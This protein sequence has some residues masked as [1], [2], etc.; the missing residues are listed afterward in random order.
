MTNPQNPYRSVI[1]NASA[2]SGKT[3]QL[4]HRFLCLVACGASPDTILTITF[5]NKAAKEMRQR[6]L[7]LASA[8]MHDEAKAAQFDAQVTAFHEAALRENEEQWGKASEDEADPQPFRRPRSAKATAREVLAWS[9]R[10]RVITIDAVF[11]N[12]QSRFAYEAGRSEA[13]SRPALGRLAVA[14]EWQSREL[15]E[16][17][18][19]LA[20]QRY[21]EDQH[22]AA[23][24]AAGALS[25]GLSPKE[26]RSRIELLKPIETFLWL[27]H[28]ASGAAFGQLP[29]ERYADAAAC[30]DYGAWFRQHQDEVAV[31]FTAIGGKKVNDRLAAIAQGDISQLQSP[32]TRLLKGDGLIS[33]SVVRG[34]EHKYQMAEINAKLALYGDSQKAQSLLAQQ[35]TLANLNG[36]FAEA[37]AEAKRA[38]G[39]LEFADAAKGCFRLFHQREY[40]SVRFYVQQHIS[41]IMID[42]FQDTNLLQWQI[43]RE[44]ALEI[45]AGYDP[46]LRGAGEYLLG[47]SVFLVGDPKQSIYRFREAEAG[48]LQSVAAELP[49]GAM[50]EVQLAHSY[51]SSPT[52]LQF[53]N[54]FFAAKIADF[55]EHL[56]ALSDGEPLI[57]DVSEVLI[58]EPFLASDDAKEKEAEWIA[59]DIATRLEAG[60]QVGPQSRPLTP[61]D[62]VILTRTNDAMTAIARALR[63]RGL[64]ASPSGGGSSGTSGSDG[65]WARPEAL[66]ALALVKVMAFPLDEQA[67]LTLLASPLVGIAE[68]ALWACL[69]QKSHR[70][71]PRWSLDQLSHIAATLLAD[72]PEL[73]RQVI[74][75]ATAGLAPSA[76]LGQLAALAHRRNAYEALFGKE[77]AELA[78]RHIRRIIH[79]L[80]VIEQSCGKD[81]SAV[82]HEL[83][84]Q[85]LRGTI[86]APGGSGQGVQIMTIHKAKGL[87][88]PLVYVMG[89]HKSWA[90]TDRYWLKSSS[91]GKVYYIGTSKTRPQSDPALAR[92]LA[93]EQDAEV[94]ENLRLLYVGLTRAS[95]Y[96]VMTGHGTKPDGG[97]HLDHALAIAA[98]EPRF[99]A[100][101]RHGQQCWQLPGEVKGQAGGKSRVEAPALAASS[102]L[103]D[104]HINLPSATS[105]LSEEYKILAPSRLLQASDGD[106]PSP[107]GAESS[108]RQAPQPKAPQARV[109]P[110]S[111]PIRWTAAEGTYIHG[112]LERYFSGADPDSIVGASYPCAFPA[113]DSQH[114]AA[115]E[116]Y[117][118]HIL[119]QPGFAAL[120]EG[121]LAADAELPMAYI[122][123]EHLIS[124]SID[125]LVVRP[126]GMATIIDF[127]TTLTPEDHEAD[128]DWHSH[129]QKNGYYRQLA[130]YR[131]GLS[132]LRP[133]LSI[134]CG[135]YYTAPGL[136]LPLDFQ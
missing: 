125:L 53:V 135:L 36:R 68:A 115:I 72:E 9:Q 98:A 128:G 121:A 107:F 49:A 130:Y 46:G 126:Q 75:L 92:L 21:W 31:L 124:G 52:V 90:R 131:E 17:S 42:E 83:L 122:D 65:L 47:P 32:P 57:D 112:C 20:F 10:L 84:Q 123:G 43:F 25:A 102:S 13:R 64:P 119:A 136:L 97:Y 5:T 63:E 60:Q 18:F 45:L 117:W 88:F 40:D 14:D 110:F 134:S 4:S 96:L 2:G 87:E 100:L 80:V 129:S 37:F 11:L 7:Q 24:D 69:S 26:L 55:P 12:W 120:T 104:Q 91:E 3:Y 113:G 66:D 109:E 23:G 58:V 56:P 76:A 94:A 127:K 22:K 38:A 29:D 78:H 28:Q 116:R 99:Q 103:G 30:A 41:H 33:G 59:R 6:I 93:A 132:R 48:L 86:K 34:E 81:P 27:A 133:E 114:R 1:V 106:A 16:R 71:K 85:S 19:R 73:Q 111:L 118:Q 89:C 51:R 70:E 8:L 62:V 79:G 15:A 35:Q 74:T 50:A 61:S 54:L 95:Q 67:W 101:T 105:L 108:S 44:L 77:D 82:Y 39:V